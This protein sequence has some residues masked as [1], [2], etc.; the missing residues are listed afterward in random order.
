[1]LTLAD[2]RTRV[3]ISLTEPEGYREGEGPLEIALADTADLIDTC[4]QINKPDYRLSATASDTV[5]DQPLCQEGNAVTFGATNFEGTIT[6]LRQTDE[7]GRIDPLTDTVYTAV[8]EKGARA[9]YLERIGPKATVA[10]AVG[11][12]GWIYEAISDA[13]Q[14]PSDRAGYVKNVIPLG[15]QSRR[16][17]VIVENGGG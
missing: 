10:L 14:E 9:W 8:G 3:D 2:G 7:D 11:D 6:V 15:V 5:P 13:P 17:F 12:A 16:Q 4:G 1:M